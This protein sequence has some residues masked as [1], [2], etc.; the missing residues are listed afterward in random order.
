MLMRTTRCGRRALWRKRKHRVAVHVVFGLWRK[1]L[2]A[3]AETYRLLQL[4]L[5]SIT[6]TF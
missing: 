1:W 6:V 3:P 5:Y 4:R 2:R